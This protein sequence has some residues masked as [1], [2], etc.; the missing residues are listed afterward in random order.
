MTL[1]KNTDQLKNFLLN[2]TFSNYFIPNELSDFFAIFEQ[3]KVP[4]FWQP[5]FEEL[6]QERSIPKTSIEETP[7]VKLAPLPE[8]LKHAFLGSDNTFPVI[9]SSK[10]SVE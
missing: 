2:S 4:K 5:R 7:K 8:G 9:I 1:Q 10:L 6:P 3:D